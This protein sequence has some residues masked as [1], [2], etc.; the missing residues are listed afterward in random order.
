MKLPIG[1]PKT[2]FGILQQLKSRVIEKFSVCNN[3]II[4][5]TQLYWYNGWETI[6]HENNCLAQ[7]DV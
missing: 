2:L 1:L 6:F 3:K 5:I 7:D 4:T